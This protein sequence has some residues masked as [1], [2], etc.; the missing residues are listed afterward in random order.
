MSTAELEQA[1]EDMLEYYR[2]P[3]HSISHSRELS[4]SLHGR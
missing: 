4:Q 2:N 3:G 1:V